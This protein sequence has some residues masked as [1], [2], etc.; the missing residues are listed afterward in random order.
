MGCGRSNDFVLCLAPNFVDRGFVGELVN[1]LVSLY[2]YI[3]LAWGSLGS[4]NISGE[5]LL[6]SLRS[7]LLQAFW[8]IFFLV[9]LEELVW[10]S[11][12]WDHH[13]GIG[14]TTENSFIVRYVL[15]VVFL[16]LP[17]SV[18]VF[19]FRLVGH[20][21]RVGSKTL[22]TFYRLL[23]GCLLYTSPSPRD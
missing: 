18:G 13:G 8:V 2:I 20:H 16:L 12:R 21:S 23:L 11:A 7:L 3:L 5:K 22:A 19:I 17:V 9:S 1:E 6:G 14:A 4:L 15:R 10:V